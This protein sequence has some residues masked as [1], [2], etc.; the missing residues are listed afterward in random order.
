MTS[1][2]RRNWVKLL[3]Q[4]IQNKTH[5]SESGSK[6]EDPLSQRRSPCQPSA[7]FTGKESRREPAAVH[8]HQD[9][10]QREEGEGWDREQ[11]KRLEER[12]KWFEEGLSFNE[13]CSRWDSMEL[14]KGSVPIP[15]IDTID[16]E[17]NRKWSEFERLSFRDMTAQSL[18]GNGTLHSNS[19]QSPDSPSDSQTLQ[20]THEEPV[21]T[22]SAAET[23][24]NYVS[25][26]SSLTNGAQN[27]QTSTAEVLQKEAI[28]LRKQVENIKQERST[29]EI[30]VDSPCG[31]GAPC[32]AK[33]EA[34]VK[35]HQKELQELQ[36]RHDQEIRELK[37]QRD[38][39]LEE[40]T[41]AAAKAVEKLKATHLG[42]MEQV[43]KAQGLRGG[44][45]ESMQKVSQLYALNSELDALS[46]QYSQK[47]LE[48]NRSEINGKSRDT[49]LKRMERDLEQLRRENQDLRARLAEE[50]SRMRCF[51]T[52]QKSDKQ[53]VGNSEKCPQIEILL[54]AKE[55]EVLCLR[56]EISCLQSEVQSLTKEKDDAYERYKGLYAQMTT[57]QGRNQLEKN[58]LTTQIKL[59]NAALYEEEQKT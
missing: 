11:A 52:G 53:P 21:E 50:I 57:T 18:I 59:A 33:L 27:S 5:Q 56:R 47:C 6:K 44:A 24:N 15:V 55:N 40:E 32:R 19:Q 36:E 45:V 4:A 22:V 2:I 51:I 16:T 54:K 49:D 28:S 20:F 25:N 9:L 35:A 58:S 13:M 26:T 1:R 31:P 41:Q 7:Q 39:M 12:N 14:K 30:E 10:S 37:E 46:E 8:S 48:L 29:L 43:T 34:M 17:V 38:K 3:K 23:T 42:E